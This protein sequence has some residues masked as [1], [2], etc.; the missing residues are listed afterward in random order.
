MIQLIPRPKKLEERGGRCLLPDV[1][2]V[3]TFFEPWCLQVFAERMR[4]PLT[5]GLWLEI[6]GHPALPE[7]GY[8]L[9]I[10]PDGV[11]VT[12]SSET[13]VIRALTTLAELEENGSFPCCYTPPRPAF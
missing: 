3:N 8:R 5:G 6:G 9:D 11:R 1:I 10:S 2:A 4:R 13:G 12:A 7:E